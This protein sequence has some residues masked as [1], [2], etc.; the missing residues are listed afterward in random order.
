MKRALLTMLVILIAGVCGCKKQTETA[1]VSHRLLLAADPYLP[2]M[3]QEVDQYISLYPEVKI[4]VR[5]ASTRGAIVSLLNDSV[6][7]IV[8]DRQCNEEERQVAQQ[9][10]LRLV[11]SKIA[12]DGI[13]IIVHKQNPIS[14]IT[15]ES[16][17]RII[18]KT[19][20]EWMQIAEARWSGPIDF[21]L[22]GRN[23]G[24]N[25]L[26]Q[27][28]IFPGSKPLE[29][30]TV[31]N[32]QREVIQYVSEHQHSIGCVAASLLTDEIVNVKILPLLTKS[33]DGSEKEYLPRQQ[34]IHE[35]LY[36]FHYSL[37]LYNTEAKA[38]VGLGFSAFV[39]SNVGQKIFQRS[40]LVP[41]SI[42]YRTIQL[43]AE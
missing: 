26:L 22:T 14:N 27:K 28:R 43:Q 40:G 32:S 35:S 21:V 13:A 19:A 8:V 38:A 29:P 41:V 20:T 4:E 9:A 1:T 30:N 7:S 33:S 15:T 6:H 2:L 42:P 12:E 11:E 17:H 37:Y 36:P 25:E 3:Q 31:I 34:E 16:V 5:G 18:T 24:M 10:S 39:L 23:S